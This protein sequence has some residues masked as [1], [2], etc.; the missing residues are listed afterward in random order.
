MKHFLHISFFIIL[1]IVVTSAVFLFAD[2]QKEKRL[3]NELRGDIIPGA[4]EMSEMQNNLNSV[5]QLLSH[6]NFSDITGNTKEQLKTVM[7]ALKEKGRSHLQ[8]EQHQ[9][10][11]A[12]KAAAELLAGIETLDS[13]V[14]KVIHMKN[15][16]VDSSS[17]QKY[18]LEM[19]HPRFEKLNNLLEH[20][21]KIHMEE[22]VAAQNSRQAATDFL[23]RTLLLTGII[24]SAALIL[25]WALIVRTFNHFQ[26]EQTQA[27]QLL[28]DGM[29]RQQKAQEEMKR[30]AAAIDQA[31]ETV[32]I[33]DSEG[34]IQY[35]NPAFE[36]LTGYTREEA[37][38]L[39]PRVLKSG[40]H[41][42]DFYADMWDTLLQGEVWHGYLINRKKDGSL[43]EEE[44][45]ISPVKNSGGRITNFVAVKRDVT[46]EVSLEKQLQQAIKMEAIGTLAGGIAHDFNNILGAILG[47]AEIARMDLP[48]A[49][50][51]VK[52]IDQVLA[53]G[54]R[55]SELVK[56]IL[57]FSRKADQ[58]KKPL[59]V[60]LIVKEALQLLRSSLPTTIDV[61]SNIDQESGLVLADPT[62]IH[63]I[64]VNLCTNASQAIGHEHG[65][66]EVT[67]KRV[68]L[69]S[70]QVAAK[71]KIQAGPFIVLSVKDSGEGIEKTAITRIFEP[72]FT[73]KRQG[74]GTGLGLAVIHGIVEDCR[75]FIDVESVP[76]KGTTFE[77]YLPA[78]QDDIPLDTDMVSN[79]PLPA[80]DERILLVDDE[81]TISDI[82]KSILDG[83]GY[84]VTAETT[85]TEALKKFQTTPDG[86]DLL[87]TD[88]TMP[89]LSGVELAQAIFELKPDFPVILCTGYTSAIS[90]SAA[91]SM[92]INSYLVKPVNTRILAETV[93]RV[94]DERSPV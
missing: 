62:S 5:P 45:S 33:T 53:A 51:T 73:T 88:Q 89:V 81:P 31:S 17:I 80:G 44:A 28:Q 77:V 9:G 3:V 10:K 18:K 71:P 35:V 84:S 94:L 91:R 92:G 12:E 46:R 40:Q 8:H 68:N 67:L 60:D 70:E 42:D 14:A 30:L 76:G 23:G 72:Y 43:F 16:Q 41:D 75:G 93:R 55:A 1:L 57:T 21:K 38:G 49:S 24:L 22:L 15:S 32:V 79:A 63:Q 20:H 82:G 87:I 74:E 48:E 78:L 50:H 85:S 54:Q 69:E 59:R 56:Q 7:M 86:F 4:I 64:V 61:Q 58:Q 13:L 27:R 19:L 2:V 83:L 37:I 65:K 90:R 66:V 34:I 11:Q 52:N 6:L 47:Y 36:N 39:N 26:V 29:A 25:I